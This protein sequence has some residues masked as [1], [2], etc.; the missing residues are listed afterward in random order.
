MILGTL[1]DL[2]IVWSTNQSDVISINGLFSDAGIEYLATDAI[3]VRIR[4]LNPGRAYIQTV[5]RSSAGRFTTS[6]E[7]TGECGHEDVCQWVC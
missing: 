7:V 2:S 5:I 4:A 3:S 6:V 1:R